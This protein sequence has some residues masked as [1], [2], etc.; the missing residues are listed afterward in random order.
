[1]PVFRLECATLANSRASIGELS[2][3]EFDE[4]WLRVFS[5]HM[6]WYRASRQWTSEYAKDE[7]IEHARA[8]IV[9]VLQPLQILPEQARRP[10]S[11]FTRHFVYWLLRDA[12]YTHA[13]H[14]TEFDLKKVTRHGLKSIDQ[15]GAFLL[16]TDDHPLYNHPNAYHTQTP[17]GQN[18][19]MLPAQTRDR[20]AAQA[21]QSESALNAIFRDALPQIVTADS[22]MRLSDISP[23]FREKLRNRLTGKYE[24]DE[25]ERLDIVREIEEEWH[26]VAAQDA[27]KKMEEAFQALG[28]EDV[29]DLPTEQALV[30][31]ASIPSTKELETAKR[32]ALELLA[33]RCAEGYD[34]KDLHRVVPAVDAY[35]KE[36][37][38][39]F[40]DRPTCG[41][42]TLALYARYSPVEQLKSRL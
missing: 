15:Q 10:E 14:M 40:C 39:A 35:L 9:D 37:T 34:E 4:H 7:F 27:F 19:K 8:K 23:K 18:V 29:L 38:I 32:T 28:I 41:V 36:F 12:V 20:K 33:L 24:L 25:S 2:H 17:R 3:K 11:Q 13:G 6:P 26:R 16:S 5:R 31:I 30:N 1:M 42:A 21:L 22:E